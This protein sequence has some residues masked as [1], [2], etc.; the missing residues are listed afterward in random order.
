MKGDKLQ[1]RVYECESS[2]TFKSTS[3]GK[4]TTQ[5]K[6]V[7]CPW[8]VKMKFIEEHSVFEITEINLMHSGHTLDPKNMKQAD[9]GFIPET[10]K[11]LIAFLVEGKQTTSNI[12]D[13]A[14]LSVKRNVDLLTGN[15]SSVVDPDD[16]LATTKKGIVTFT[17]KDVVARVKR[18]FKQF[19]LSSQS[20]Y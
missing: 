1:V 16:L 2:G 11:G 6:R 8:K 17:K 15:R 13:L 3:S 14:V 5:S 9:T 18:A 20:I 4:R 7:G 10:V 19:L 12:Y